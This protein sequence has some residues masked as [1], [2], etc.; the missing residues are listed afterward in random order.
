MSLISDSVSLPDRK[1]IWLT[2]PSAVL[3]LGALMPATMRFCGLPGSEP[4]QAL[5]E[6]LCLPA[7]LGLTYNCWP[8]AAS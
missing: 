3:I 4:W 6:Q 5:F 8:L 2:P 1:L 7:T